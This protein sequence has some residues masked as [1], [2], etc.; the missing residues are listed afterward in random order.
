MDSVGF[1]FCPELLRS[2]L[3]FH[4]IRQADLSRR[5]NRS[6]SYVS[7]VLTGFVTPTATEAAIIADL[8]KAPVKDLFMDTREDPK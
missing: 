1:V 6:Q 4:K 2:L 7:G 3:T 8:V 5:L